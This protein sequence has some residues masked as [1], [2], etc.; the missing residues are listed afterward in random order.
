MAGGRIEGLS[1]RRAAP[2]V[3]GPIVRASVWAAP[4]TVS[5]RCMSPVIKLGIMPFREMQ[6][7]PE[8]TYNDCEHSF[9]VEMFLEYAPARSS[10][11]RRRAAGR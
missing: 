8:C 1:D 5:S 10:G 9:V 2:T 11:D 4:S 3:T 6:H 7:F